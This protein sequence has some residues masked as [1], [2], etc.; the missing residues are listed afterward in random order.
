MTTKTRKDTVS[1]A[2]FSKWFKAASKP[3]RERFFTIIDAKLNTILQ[4]TSGNRNFSAARAGEIAEAMRL[5]AKTEE[6]APRPLTRGDL[7]KA[8]RECEYFKNGEA[9]DVDDLK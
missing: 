8:C 7:C 1:A 3:T 9:L 2:H 4:Y 6:K 5:I